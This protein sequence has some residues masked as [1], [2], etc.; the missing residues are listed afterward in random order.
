MTGENTANFDAPL[1]G[2]MFLYD[3]PEL[4]TK[5]E[6]GDLGICVGDRPYEFARGAR[7]VPLTVNEIASAQKSYPVVFSEEEAP[8]P[9]AVVGVQ[10]DRNLF[11]DEGGRWD[12][13]CYVP[14]YL[15]CYPFALARKDDR[16]AVV[17]DRA[18]AKVGKNPDVPFFDDGE[19]S[20]D[21]QKIADFCVRVEEER[22]QTR[23]FMDRLQALGL[24][25]KQ[26]S[27]YRPAGSDTEVPLA[28]YQG[29]DAEKLQNIDSAVLEEL[30]RNGYLWAALAQLYSL[31]NWQRL[32]RRRES[33]SA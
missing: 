9:L 26:G 17:I 24:L 1:T 31:E 28:S 32:M 20:A 22:Q 33:R 7:F 15:R 4:L 27:T 29:I 14:N 5:E 3:K 10:E 23:L 6:H 11:V 12:E 13:D 30:H 25:S 8:I 16:F 18:S 19:L 2:S 21:V